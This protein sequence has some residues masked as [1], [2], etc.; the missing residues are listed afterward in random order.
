MIRPTTAKCIW[1]WRLRDWDQRAGSRV[2]RLAAYTAIP[3]RRS[4]LDVSTIHHNSTGIYLNM[5]E[6]SNWLLSEGEGPYCTGDFIIIS[7]NY[8]EK[9]LSYL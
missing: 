8:L 2:S 3:L 1:P 5:P 7:V 9:L 4:A 6:V